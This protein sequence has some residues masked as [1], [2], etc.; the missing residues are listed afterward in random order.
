MWLLTGGVIYA[1]YEQNWQIQ[2]M[3]YVGFAL[4]LPLAVSAERCR[5]DYELEDISDDLAKRDENRNRT[6]PPNASVRE[7]ETEPETSPEQDQFDAYGN[8]GS[9][10]FGETDRDPRESF[11]DQAD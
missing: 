9:E 1:Q 10:T 11:D 3:I 6:N 8:T 7:D 2:A 5:M 4:L